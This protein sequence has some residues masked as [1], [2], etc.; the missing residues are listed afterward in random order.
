M[1]TRH[2]KLN[3]IRYVQG[4]VTGPARLSGARLCTRRMTTNE[5]RERLIT[6]EHS[7]HDEVPRG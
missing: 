6:A 2:G 1:A 4:S 5:L 3:R 7:R